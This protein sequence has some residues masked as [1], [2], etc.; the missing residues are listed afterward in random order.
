MKQPQDI[1]GCRETFQLFITDLRS[2]GIWRVNVKSSDD[3]KSSTSE[4][5][6]TTEYRPST[7]STT[8][9]RLSVTPEY[10]F[11]SRRPYL[12]DV[13]DVLNGDK[14]QTIHLPNYMRPRHAVET[15]QSTFIVLYEMMEYNEVSGEWT[16]VKVVSED[17]SER[18]VFKVSELTNDGDVI[19]QSNFQQFCFPHHL[20]IDSLNKILIADTENNRIVLLDKELKFEKI[21]L[22]EFNKK[23]DRRPLPYRLNY[24]KDNKQLIVGMFRSPIVDVYHWK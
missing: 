10:Y 14:L 12:I 20:V 23:H 7:M 11:A 3:I 4:E 17:G 8:S 18:S 21:L 16:E 5:F 1:V 9:R 15:E 13:F 19:R 22:E 2:R 6:I 24:N